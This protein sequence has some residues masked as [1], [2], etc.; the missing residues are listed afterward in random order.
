LLFQLAHKRLAKAPD[1]RGIPARFVESAIRTDPRAEWE[2]NVEM[3]D[4]L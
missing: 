1:L 4:Q 3:A 2:M